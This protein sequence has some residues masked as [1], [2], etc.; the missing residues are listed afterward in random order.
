MKIM[1]V[2]GIVAGIHVFVLI[3]IFANP[4]CSTS[5]RPPPSPAETVAM[6]EPAPMI[7]LPGSSPASDPAPTSTDFG[8]GTS[9]SVG[10]SVPPGFNPDAPATYG[11]T[12]TRFNPTRPNTPAAS[13]VTAAPVENVTPATTYVVKPG[14]SLWSL[15]K[16]FRVDYREIAAANNLNT[17]ATLAQGKRLI[18]PAKT[19]APRST[20][21][22][23]PVAA[24]SNTTAVARTEER[25]PATP[26]RANGDEVTYVVKPG[27]TLDAIAKRHGVSRRE[28]GT[29][30]HI[31][32]P[33]RLQPGTEL[34]IPGYRAP[35]AG[36]TAAS[37]V[38]STGTQT[39]AAPTPAPAEPPTL[40]VLDLDQ[41]A[42]PAQSPTTTDVPVIRIDGE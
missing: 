27:D 24:A 9:T 38:T 17:S 20:S 29:A 8:T 5:T 11:G 33:Q 7:T 15:G 36:S 14:D 35:A 42:P 18:I 41:S 21:P 34:V 13:A 3:V 26:A 22:A 12:S 31:T 16:K 10:S 19:A 1:K 4:G 40:N 39:P 28:L 25:V 37:P 2:F 32:N 23:T 6:S 30:N